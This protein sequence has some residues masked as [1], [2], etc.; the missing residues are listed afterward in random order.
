MKRWKILNKIQNSKIKNQ[1]F[2]IKEIIKALLENRGLKTQ[3]EIDE[4]LNPDISKI[5]YK[6]A[7]I[8][9]KDIK[10]SVKRIKDAVANNEKIIIFGDYDVDGICGTAILWE[11][12]YSFYRNVFPY[13]PDRVDEGY[14]LSCN[15]ISN[16]K[17]QKSKINDA[18]LIITVDNGI[19]AN[20]A[21]D[22]AKKEGIDVIITDHHA[23]PK[24]LPKAYS[25]VHTTKLCGAGVAYLLAKEVLNKIKNFK[26][27]EDNHLEL[28]ALA[29]IADLVPLSGS[30][31]V[32]V[33]EGLRKLTATKRPGLLHLYKLAGIDNKNLGVYEVGY[34]IGPRLNA[35]GRMSS[36]MDSLRLVCTKNMQKANIYAGNLDR[37]NRER[38]VLTEETA[39]HAISLNQNLSSKIVFVY[40]AEYNQGIIG[41]VASKLVEDFYRPSFVLSVGEKYSKGSARSISG[42]NIIDLIRSVPSEL[43]IDA[44]GHPMAAG[45]TV[46]TNKIED[47]KQELEKKANEVITDDLLQRVVRIDLVLGFND[48]NFDLY[49]KI[50]TLSPFGI[51][52]P[53]PV[54][55]TQDAFVNDM[56]FVGRDKNHLKL[57][58]EKDGVI[59]DAIAFGFGQKAD[60]AVNDKID[61]AYIIDN[62]SWNGNSKL[63]LK[64]KDVRKRD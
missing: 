28:V 49:G 9:I 17:D 34:I 26:R 21:V 45:F 48:V 8:D 39:I 18:K 36:A 30:S 50:Q 63:Q 13:I 42:V 1:K 16:I 37:T 19:S 58:I 51:G 41:L 3:K 15:G 38:Q 52:N 61:V 7:G 20:E 29:T 53:E 14:G 46:H 60:F 11:S 6:K 54:F 24:I 25:I 22:F 5:D 27:E 64:I 55:A 33:K 59:F 47:F 4:F 56:N 31:R 44:G 57:K 40:Q 35:M 10:R 32:F 23:L 2:E 12:L 43:L 62:N